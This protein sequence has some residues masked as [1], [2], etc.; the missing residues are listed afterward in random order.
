MIG[1]VDVLAV[2][3]RYHYARVISESSVQSTLLRIN[4]Q[5]PFVY[6][7]K[8]FTMRSL[9]LLMLLFSLSHVSLGAPRE[10]LKIAGATTVSYKTVGDTT[11]FLYIFN[12]KDHQ[13]SDKQSA[14]VFFFGGGWN[15]G[16]PTQFEHHC[17]Y[18]ASRGM[19]AMVA[20]YRVKNRQGTTPKE[21]VMDG[22]SV[23][24]WIR[25]NAANLGV[26]PQR[27][28]AGGGSAGGH[29]AAA[30]GT[31]VGM[32]QPGENV[33]VSSKPNALMLFNPVYDNSPNGYGH[34]RVKDVY[35]QISPMHNIKNGT[36]P[37]VVFL[38]TKDSLIPVATANE[39]KKRMEAAGS[40]CDLHLYEGQSH[41]FFNYSNQK[42]YLDT[43]EKMD[44]FLVSL[45][46]VELN[47]GK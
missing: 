34:S 24:R 27:I 11:L 40:R 42:C 12:P 3:W 14:T 38:G 36:P 35:P 9:P 7:L 5:F 18:L 32:E 31:V 37:T 47:S 23:V 39:Y 17:R 6:S 45:K 25:S 4:Q 22:K 16:T 28:V 43:V 13:K 46:Y 44:A 30:T 21:C 19:V 33:S 26:D 15:G 20:D 1:V 10:P 29:V 2:E 8:R 41:G